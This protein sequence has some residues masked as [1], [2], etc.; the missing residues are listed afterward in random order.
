LEEA[1]A[2]ANSN[3]SVENLDEGYIKRLAGMINQ[4]TF[5]NRVEEYRGMFE[6][7]RIPSA[8]WTPPY[9]EKIPQEMEAFLKK[10]NEMLS[11]E[12]L[13]LTIEGS[14]YANFQLIRIHP[15]N[16]GNGRTSRIIQNLILR[17][18]GLPPVDIYPGERFAYYKL[19]DSAVHGYRFNSGSN[20]IVSPQERE[21]YNYLAGK[22][23]SSLDLMLDK[24]LG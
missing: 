8:S 3:Y 19:L 17:N 14:C 23:S 2:W 15:F 12:D 24:T 7:V 16:D 13:D 1:Y 5:E 21:L 6:Q 9:S 20:G 10:L 18:A 22:V 11:K 4:E